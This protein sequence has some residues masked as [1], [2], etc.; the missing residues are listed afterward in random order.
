M[1][2]LSLL[3]FDENYNAVIQPAKE[4]YDFVLPEK[5]IAVFFEEVVNNLSK[6][7]STYEIGR[8]KWETGDVIFYGL[9]VGGEK[10]CFYHS[11]V[12]APISAAVMDLA[13]ALGGKYFISIGGCGIIDESKASEV[14][15]LPYDGV[16]NEGTS[17]HYASPN[18]TIQPS[19]FLFESIRNYLESNDIRYSLV[20][21]WT[22]D[23][24]YRETENKVR[25]Q[26]EN[27]CSTVEMEFTGLCAV[28]SLRQIHYAALF[29]SGDKVEAGA[30]DER[31]WQD[32]FVVREQLF[33]IVVN[34]L[35]EV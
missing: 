29:Y 16:R 9:D 11:W 33:N 20:K 7:D 25:Y 1:I 28:A 26:K 2:E 30:Y 13:I 35:L 22:T 27:G 14:F 12:G 31:G 5:C 19:R 21:T 15:L 4:D 23:G 32:N 8:V 10:L 3:T 34:I 18:E 24:F 17:F 6:L